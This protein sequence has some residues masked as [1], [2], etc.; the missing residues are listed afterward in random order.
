MEVHARYILVGL[1]ALVVIGSGFA[2]VSWLEAGGGLG[3]R[4]SYRIRFSDPVAG[5]SKGSAVL[6][7]GVRI[8]EVTSL[9]LDATRPSD[10]LAEVAVDGKAPIRADTKVGIDFQGLAGAP[11]IALAGGSPNLPLLASAHVDARL[12]TAEKNAGQTMTQAARDVLRNLDVVISE[13][14]APL[15]SAISNIDKFT[16]ALAKNADKVD[17]ILSGLDRLTGGGA[18]PS[19]RIVELRPA[20]EFSRPPPASQVHL[21]L[22]IPEPTALAHLESDK[23]LLS[24]DEKD[25]LENAQWPDVLTRV[26]QSSLVRSFEYAGYRR[27][28]GRAPEGAKS[29]AQLLIDIR[30]FH[31]VQKPAPRAEIELAARVLK[32]DGSISDVQPFAARVP[33][34]DSGPPTAADALND[35]FSRV[36]AEVVAWMSGVL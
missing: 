23:I 12:L 10:V 13:N 31:V 34:G 15:R 2:F 8:G 9:G 21:Q 28:L 27:V 25:R 5:L 36:A 33:F 19:L 24:N 18:K 14:S 22:Q 35:A 26:V 17:G 3:E 6:F 4:T 29:D 30:R 11:T 32:A 20:T 1:F 7:N 16:E